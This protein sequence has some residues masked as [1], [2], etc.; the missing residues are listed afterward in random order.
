MI[1]FAAPTF[2]GTIMLRAVFIIACIFAA[3][4]VIT[5]DAGF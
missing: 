3:G 4:A 5:M 1:T 2:A